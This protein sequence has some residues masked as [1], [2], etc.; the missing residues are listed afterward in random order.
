MSKTTRRNFLKTTATVSAGYFVAAGARP[1]LSQSPNQKPNVVCIGVGGKGGS[2]SSNAAKFGNVIVDIA[3][4]H[5]NC[6]FYY[7]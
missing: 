6:I 2:D 3:I 1:A 7:D 4:I 5:K